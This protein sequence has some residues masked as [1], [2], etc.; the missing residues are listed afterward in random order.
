MRYHRI[1][2]A[3]ALTGLVVATAQG[4][5]IGGL[6]KK[7]VGDAVKPKEEQPPKASQDESSPF[8]FEL[9]TE[10]MAAFKRGLEMEIR[11]RADYRSGVVKHA[12]ATAAYKKCEQGIPFRP[13]AS[14]IADEGSSRMDKAKTSEETQSAMQWMQ[15][16]MMGLTTKVCG[17]EP[18]LAPDQ[19]QSFRKAEEAAATE[20]A[21]GLTRKS[22]R[23]EPNEP[24]EDSVTPE[25]VDGCL[26]ESESS[27]FASVPMHLGG[28]C[29]HSPAA[30]AAPK[31][32]LQDVETYL[33]DYR[34]TKEFVVKYCSLSPE[35]R[36]D[37]EKNGIRVPGAGE[38]VYWIFPRWFAV[39]VGPDCDHLI[40]LYTVLEESSKQPPS[41]SK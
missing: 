26:E 20:F 11:M 35:M 21:K 4:Q 7:K 39:W 32:R 17:A 18:G 6:I 36:A 33:H 15:K 24:R 10:A 29:T 31:P 25:I 9:T 37:A 3:L 19:T 28:E 14:K 16:E 8:A 5:G 23:E 38:K 12:A 27:D 34:T 22:R 2:L 41:P 30:G 1:T 13:E 40:K